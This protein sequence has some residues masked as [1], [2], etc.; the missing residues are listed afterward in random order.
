MQPFSYI[1]G[2]TNGTRFALNALLPIT[3]SSIKARDLRQLKL[4]QNDSGWLS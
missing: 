4:D 3:D 1:A 2:H